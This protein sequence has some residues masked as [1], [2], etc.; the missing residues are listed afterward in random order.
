M[1]DSTVKQFDFDEWHQLANSDPDAFEQKRQKAINKIIQ[2]APQAKQ[3]R[4]RCLQWRIDQTRR[5]STTPLAACIKISKLMWNSVLGENGLL[6]TLQGLEAE[7]N[8][9]SNKS[10]GRI[11][12]GS[13]RTA[14]ILRFQPLESV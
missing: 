3:K 13:R 1:A 5:L 4:L 10:P 12:S 9:G 11:S 2:N 14:K 8:P 6:V 7:I